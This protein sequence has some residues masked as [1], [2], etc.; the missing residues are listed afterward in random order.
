MERQVKFKLQ[1][2]ILQSG[3]LPEEH[4]AMLYRGARL[5]YDPWYSAYFL[6]RGDF[7]EFFTYFNSLSYEK[8]RKYTR[9]GEIYL[10]LR[11]KGNFSVQLFGHYREGREI[12]KEFYPVHEIREKSMREVEIPLPEHVNGTVIGFQLWAGEGFSIEGGGWYTRV[13]REQV[14]EIRISVATTTFRKEDYITRNIGVL[15]R[16]LFYS[17]EPC[18][19]C[20]HLRVIDNGRTLDPEK[21]N[22]EYVTVYP[23]INAGGAGGF[24]RGI[25]ES[26][27]SAQDPTHILLM[28]DDVTV[29]PEALIRTYSLL[30]LLK[31]EYR[32]CF[33]SGA[34]LYY[35]AMNIQHEDVGYVHEDGSYGPNKR[36]MDMSRWDSVFENAEEMSFHRDSY[37]GWW[38]CCIP[39]G[40][41]RTDRL[42][43]PVFI[44]GDDVEFSISNKAGFLTL[45]GICIWHKGFANKFNASLELYLVHRNSMVIQAAGGILEGKDFLKRINGFFDSNLKRIA[46]GNCDLLLDAVED[47]LKGPEFLMSPRGEQITKE[48]S[49]KNERLTD[50]RLF[51]GEIGGVDLGEASGHIYEPA[52]LRGF[53]RFL[54]DV[55]WNYHFYPK[56]LLDK[57]IGVIP[58]DWFDAPAKNYK[59]EKLLAVNAH[60]QTGYLR[61]RSRKR[62]LELLKRRRRLMK[63]F[64]REGERVARRYGEMAETLRSEE[65]WR[66]YLGI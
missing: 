1:N 65:F 39:A 62:C 12:R 25:L 50:L 18:R 7:T 3:Q 60:E 48:K 17:D 9:A 66:G 20:F 4:T 46:Y 8:W 2:L 15:E 58:Y 38:Y 27:H 42:P 16:E 11:A 33:I 6:N 37:A 56:S 57:K 26:R 59:K 28:D 51:E 21:Y 52:P 13:D 40:T 49:A 10:V 22:S 32:S 44:R 41:A 23:N 24:T 45:G 30:A 47:Y 19:N 61:V 54:Y 36:I 64:R 14:R 29:L 43:L 55:T 5:R 35:E 31:E 34:M 63:Q 53:R